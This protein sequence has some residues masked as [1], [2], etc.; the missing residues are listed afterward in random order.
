[1]SGSRSGGN[2][3]RG[4]SESAGSPVIGLVN[5]LASG[6]LCVEVRRV[7]PPAEGSEAVPH[8]RTEL[9]V[10]LEGELLDGRS[11]EVALDA[12]LGARVQDHEPEP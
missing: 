9:G 4:A 12:R 10:P 7:E 2:D 11:L 1:M 5:D 8:I 6:A 3:A